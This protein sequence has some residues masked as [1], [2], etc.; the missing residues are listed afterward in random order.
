M[1]KI[2]GFPDFE[3]RSGLLVTIIQDVATKEVLMHGSMNRAALWLT[4][5]TKTVWLW[6]TSRQEMWHKGA[7]SDSVMEVVWIKHDC[8]G[9]AIL[10]G[11]KVAGTGHAC[12]KNRVS[13]FDNVVECDKVPDR[14]I[15]DDIDFTPKG[16]AS[17]V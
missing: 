3:K 5:H 13:C 16:G 1:Q 7:T 11:V 15:F 17:H 14:L 12:H 2:E 9:D 6:S 10:V 8:D 4:L